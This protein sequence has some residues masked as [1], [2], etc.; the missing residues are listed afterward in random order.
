[1]LIAVTHA[2]LRTQQSSLQR[3]RFDVIWI[4]SQRTRQ[5]ET[6]VTFAANLQQR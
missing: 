1:M 6:G 5:S 3:K 4:V 2:P